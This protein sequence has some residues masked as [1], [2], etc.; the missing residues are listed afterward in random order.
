MQTQQEIERKAVASRAHSTLVYLP[1]SNRSSATQLFLAFAQSLQAPALRLRR[2]EFFHG[3]PFGALHMHISHAN[4]V[5]CGF[6]WIPCLAHI[7]YYV[8]VL[9]KL[10][11]YMLLNQSLR[12]CTFML[13]IGSNGEL[14]LVWLTHSLAKALSTHKQLRARQGLRMR[15]LVVGTCAFLFNCC[16]ISVT[17]WPQVSSQGIKIFD[18]RALRWVKVSYECIV[19]DTEVYEGITI[20]R[21][22]FYGDWMASVWRLL[23]FASSVIR[24][25]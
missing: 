13:P 17:A 14:K 22:H 21:R 5:G 12:Y 15:L 18:G 20:I 19:C 9:L 1:E 3:Y 11:A 4:T 24:S 6:K 8:Q 10:S 25:C 7:L 16:W 2:L 23:S